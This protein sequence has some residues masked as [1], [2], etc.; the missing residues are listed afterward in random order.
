M[1]SWTA[2]PALAAALVLLNASLTF[3]NVWPTPKIRWENA[4]SVELAVVVLMLALLHRHAKTLTRRL[5]PTLW[6]AL[7]A[8]H[9]LDV[10]APGLYGRDFNLYWDSQHLGNVTAMLARAV[11]P[12]LI[13]LGVTVVITLVAT[14]WLLSRVALRQVAG[15]VAHRG[16]RRA[17]MALSALLIAAFA[18]TALADPPGTTRIFANP[19]TAAYARQAR[20]VIA[21]A[22]PDRAAPALADSPEMNGRLDGLAGADVLLAFVEAYGAVTYDNPVFAEALGPSRHDLAE[23]AREAGRDVVSAFVDSPTFGASSWL[24]H[25][26]LLTGVEVRDQ[27]AYVAVMSSARDTLP[28]AFR[29]QGYRSV[30]VMP[31]MRQ[32]WPEGAFY[33]FD[34]IHGRDGLAYGGPRFG[35]W[36]IPD[37]FTLAKFD[38]LELS[39][40]GRRPVFAVFPTSTSH[41]PF[42]PVAPYQ[43]E[44]PKLLTA[45][46]FDPADVERALAASPDLTNLSPSY[47]KAM[48]YE[49]TTFAGYVRQHAGDDL[50]LILIGDHQP[51]AAVSGSGATRE[52]PI[53]VL[54][55]PGVLMDRLRAEGFIDGVE[56]RRPALGSMPGL[57]PILLRA[58]GPLTP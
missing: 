58:F 49:F 34:E 41:A 55:R 42:G 44:W 47:A 15:A 37:Q 38:Q 10:T 20:F 18:G 17:L 28:K 53:H 14:V 32:A 33:G 40:P 3:G 39:Q 30:A 45:S 1:R 31:G 26:S 54:A 46:A 52:V 35:W 5:V 29:R 36:S 11:P 25:L 7:V 13:A 8:G 56:P 23:A 16:P 43:P 24:A 12:W 50:V 48:A 22:G 27:Y 51:V 19:T 57:V 4:L 21:M 6:V 2:W 9:Y